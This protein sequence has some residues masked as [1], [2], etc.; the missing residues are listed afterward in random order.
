MTNGIYLLSGSN[1]GDRAANLLYALDL[2]EQKSIS[3]VTQSEL[4]ET[5]AWGIESQPAFLNQVVEVKTELS[6]E[7]LLISL[8]ETEEQMGR[9]REVKWGERLIDIDILYYADRILE[10]P[11]LTI[12]HPHIQDRRFTLVPLC[13]LVPLLVH[14]VLRKTQQELLDLCPDPLEVRLF[15][16]TP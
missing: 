5:A 16:Q 14:P 7:A 12:P 15:R 9:K 1:L 3:V 10:S 6:P 4:Y 2:L 13:E 11:G 8:L